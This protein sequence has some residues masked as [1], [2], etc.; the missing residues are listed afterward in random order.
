MR[1]EWCSMNFCSSLFS[2]GRWDGKKCRKCF[3]SSASALLFELNYIY[4]KNIIRFEVVSLLIVKHLLFF[5]FYLSF[6]ISQSNFFIIYDLV[7]LQRVDLLLNLIA[8]AC[9]ITTVWAM[10]VRATVT[11]LCMKPFMIPMES[12]AWGFLSWWCWIW[13]SVGVTQQSLRK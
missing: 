4:K 10:I 13:R 2:F 9:N 8:G 11:K 1:E 6:E 12:S 5:R 7:F 3:V